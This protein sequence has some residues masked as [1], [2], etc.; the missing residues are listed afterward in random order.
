MYK[1]DL[2]PLSILCDAQQLFFETDVKK[3]LKMVKINN[4]K[5]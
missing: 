3:K 4:I 1:G 2:S 5:N